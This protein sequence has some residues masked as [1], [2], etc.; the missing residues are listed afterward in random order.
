MGK[1]AWRKVKRSLPVEQEFDRPKE[2]IVFKC[3]PVNILRFPG[4]PPGKT[5]WFD[6]KT[7]VE[8]CLPESDPHAVSKSHILNFFASS[9]LGIQTMASSGYREF[10]RLFFAHLSDTPVSRQMGLKMGPF[11]LYLLLF[12]SFPTSDTTIN[13]PGQPGYICRHFR[14]PSF[15]P[16]LKVRE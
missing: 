9:I 12:F 15:S 6:L 4:V 11:R 2:E 14:L 16:F 3:F 5:G 13:S 8:I 10:R 1:F 7:P